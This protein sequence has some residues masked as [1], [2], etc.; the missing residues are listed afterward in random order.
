MI[1][2]EVIDERDFEKVPVKTRRKM[3][4]C[5]VIS[6]REKVRV[7]IRITEWGLDCSGEFLFLVQ[8]QGRRSVCKTGA[9][10]Q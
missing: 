5:V 6:E 7:E 9:E 8:E 2:L 10:L 4:D 3:W 1:K